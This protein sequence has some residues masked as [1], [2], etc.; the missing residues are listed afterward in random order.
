MSHFARLQL[1]GRITYYLGWIALVSG[2][3]VHVN[4]ARGVFMSVGLS[5]RNL[6]ELSVVSFLIC[7]ASELRVIADSGSEKEVAQPVVREMAA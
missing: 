5:Q 6:F 7:V 1:V 2:C 3:L 4:V